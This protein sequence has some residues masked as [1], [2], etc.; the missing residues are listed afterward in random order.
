MTD[1]TL[2]GIAEAGRLLARGD[3]TATALTESF[4]K[5]IDAVDKKLLSYRRSG[6]RRRPPGRPGAE[7]RRA[8]RTDARHPGGAQGHL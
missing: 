6:A 5:R 7:G 3:V 1:L 8:P 4:L 2:L